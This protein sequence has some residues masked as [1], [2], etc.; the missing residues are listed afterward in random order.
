[1]LTLR[2]T[3]GQ[4]ALEYV[5]LLVVVI[6]ALLAAGKYFRRAKEGGIREAADQIGG[7]FSAAET[8]TDYTTVTHS[9]RSDAVT[10]TGSSTQTFVDPETQTKTGSETV[11]GQVTGNWF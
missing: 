2:K 6:A 11:Q 5:V 8:T 3:R 1:M 7:Q 10:N 4:T 9:K